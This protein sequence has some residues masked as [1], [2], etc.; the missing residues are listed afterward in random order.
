MPATVKEGKVTA[1][2]LP[3]GWHPCTVGTFKIDRLEL[4]TDPEPTAEDYGFSLTEAAGTT[5]VGRL[6]AIIAV[7]MT[8]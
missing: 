7:R 2:L 6:S 8:A 4:K 3:T 5:I 1:V